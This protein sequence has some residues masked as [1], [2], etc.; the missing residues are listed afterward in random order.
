MNNQPA[1]EEFQR[2]W[3]ALAQWLRLWFKLDLKDDQLRDVAML[4]EAIDKALRKTPETTDRCINRLRGVVC[5]HT[6]AQHR[7]CEHSNSF[8]H[9][10]CRECYCNNFVSVY[11]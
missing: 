3:N 8:T 5:N 9:Y 10:I 1:N 4:K 7:R 6:K 11:K 2:G